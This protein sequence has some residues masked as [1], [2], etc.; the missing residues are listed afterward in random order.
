[1]LSSAPKSKCS[2]HRCNELFRETFFYPSSRWLLQSL[3]HCVY[4]LHYLNTGLR[5]VNIGWSLQHIAACRLKALISPQ[6]N[7]G[8]K[9]RIRWRRKVLCDAAAH[10]EPRLKS[11]FV[12]YSVMVS[13]PLQQE[14]ETKGVR[15]R[16]IWWE[17]EEKRN[18]TR[19]E[20]GKTNTLTFF[21]L[22]HLNDKLKWFHF[23][24]VYTYFSTNPL[25]LFFVKSSLC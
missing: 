23:Q 5:H 21:S 2:A 10:R 25:L 9:I 7:S 1:M 14:M 16:V 20:G 12:N 18:E 4:M 17:W 15:M 24:Q 8:A 11:G 22:H 6:L 13:Q 3:R 19:W